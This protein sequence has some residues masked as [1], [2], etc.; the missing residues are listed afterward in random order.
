MCRLCDSPAAAVL[1]HRLASIRARVES[2]S[3]AACPSHGGS[4]GQGSHGLFPQPP[5]SNGEKPRRKRSER[6]RRR[7]HSPNLRQAC[8]SRQL[9]TLTGSCKGSAF[10]HTDAGVPRSLWGG[11]G[12]ISQG[13]QCSCQKTTTSRSRQRQLREADDDVAADDDNFEKYLQVHAAPSR[14]RRR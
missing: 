13:W 14:R 9:E 2:K 6:C 1:A 12:S 8:Q 10:Q 5:S 7:A 3:E 4:L 11:A